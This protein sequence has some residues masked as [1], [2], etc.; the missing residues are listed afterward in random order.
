MIKVSLDCV[1]IYIDGNRTAISELVTNSHVVGVIIAAICAAIIITFVIA[2]VITLVIAFDARRYCPARN[3]AYVPEDA[4]DTLYGCP[5]MPAF[6]LANATEAAAGTCVISSRK[7]MRSPD[8][9]ADGDDSHSF[10]H[11]L[12]RPPP[13]NPA[14][15]FLYVTNNSGAGVSIGP[16]HR[17]VP[18]VGRRGRLTVGHISY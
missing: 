7:S 2:S 16:V 5:L 4:L 11:L 1:L 10:P 13:P 6:A 9:D 14:H 15:L 18:A 3:P 8:T 12:V 17:L